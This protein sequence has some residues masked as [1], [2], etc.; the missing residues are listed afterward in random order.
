MMKK[1]FSGEQNSASA[2][3]SYNCIYVYVADN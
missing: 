2:V 3:N 1:Y